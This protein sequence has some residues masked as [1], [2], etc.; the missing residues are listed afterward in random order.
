MKKTNLRIIPALLLLMAAILACNLPVSGIKPASQKIPV[1]DQA[2][3]S[4]ESTVTSNLE[5]ASPSQPVVITL[6]EEQI[7]SYMAKYLREN[8]QFPVTDPQVHLRNGQVEI[9]GKY[10]QG[11]LTANIKLIVNVA[12]DDQGN[13]KATITSAD[14]GPIPAPTNMLDTLSATINEALMGNLGPSVIGL[15]ISSIQVSDGTITISGTR[16]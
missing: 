14:F 5:N 6:S 11:V 3:Q 15:K 4:L 16:Q 13:P 2:A 12:L 9:D 1:S 8:K 7:T 10:Q